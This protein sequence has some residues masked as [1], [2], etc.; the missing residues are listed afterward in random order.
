[1]FVLSVQSTDICIHCLVI[2]KDFFYP[3]NLDLSPKTHSSKDD[4]LLA[5]LLF[6]RFSLLHI[7][8]NTIF[9]IR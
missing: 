1:M 7:D 3:R 6:V 9:S 2:L 4:V 8:V 5:V